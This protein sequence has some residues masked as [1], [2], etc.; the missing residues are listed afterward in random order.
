MTK[1]LSAVDF[2]F[3]MTCMEENS[4]LVRCVARH[5]S[6]GAYKVHFLAELCWFR[7]ADALQYGDG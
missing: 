1:F 4:L 6:P 5:F 2:N 3:L 7:G